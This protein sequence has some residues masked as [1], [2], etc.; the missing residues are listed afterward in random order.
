M[1]ASVQG[2]GE[3][4]ISVRGD[5]VHAAPKFLTCIIELSVNSIKRGRF[6]KLA[7]RKIRNEHLITKGTLECI[8][9]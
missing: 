6:E 1:A 3:N 8:S 5:L 4:V 9:G 2:L 7:G